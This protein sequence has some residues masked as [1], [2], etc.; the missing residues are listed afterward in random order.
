MKFRVLI[1][2]FFFLSILNCNS[3]KLKCCNTKDD[4]QR[5]LKGNWVIKNNHSSEIYQYSFDGKNGQMNTFDKDKFENGR[6]PL[7][8]HS[9]F[10]K[11]RR[12]LFGGFKINYITLYG[13]RKSKIKYLDN[14]KMILETDLGELIEYEKYK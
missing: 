3:Q 6:I 5:I 9:S 8:N 1:F 7:N 4:V 13:S 11:L 10:I 14:E 2:T 12:G